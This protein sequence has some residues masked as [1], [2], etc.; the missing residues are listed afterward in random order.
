M[1]FQM[2]EWAFCSPLA[3]PSPAVVKVHRGFP[4]MAARASSAYRKVLELAVLSLFS[5]GS[6]TFLHVAQTAGLLG[7][8]VEVPQYAFSKSR[9]GGV[10]EE[11][12]HA[13][14]PG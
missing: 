13:H 5:P 9:L 10:S 12:K 6:R 4:I 1:N 11:G 7:F 2:S 8:P 14:Y 3:R